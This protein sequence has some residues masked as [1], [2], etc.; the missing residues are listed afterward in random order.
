M[1]NLTVIIENDHNA[2]LDQL[3]SLP[4][5]NRQAAIYKKSLVELYAQY[6]AL[7]DNLGDTVK[8][9]YD[10]AQ[11]IKQRESLSN[12]KQYARV[13]RDQINEVLNKPVK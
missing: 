9:Y 3:R 12:G 10:V 11:L 7:I 4:F 13:K 5:G 6:H 2:L 8:A 1:E